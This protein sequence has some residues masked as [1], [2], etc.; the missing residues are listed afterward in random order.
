MFP[1][2]WIVI[3][4]LLLIILIIFIKMAIKIVQE[5]E[6]MV[7]ERFGKFREVLGPG[8]HVIVPI[9]D[10]ARNYQWEYMVSSP[11]GRLE[12]KTKKSDRVSTQN[13]VL[14]FAKQVVITRDNAQ[15]HLDALI[16]YKIFDPKQMIYST[17]N[18]PH[19]LAKLLQAQLRNVAANMDVDQVIEDTAAMNI[20]GGMMDSEAKRWGVTIDWVRCQKV[21]APS[22]LASY[23]AKKKNADLE[24]K[25][26]TI[27]AKAQKQ[28]RIIESEGIRDSQIRESEGAAQAMLQKARG[29]AQAIVNAGNAEARSIKEIGRVISQVAGEDPVRYFLSLKYLDALRRIVSTANTSVEYLPHQTALL[30]TITDLGL[31]TIFPPSTL[32]DPARLASLWNQP[33]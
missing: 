16:C 14:D 20:M 7:I 32:A 22:D 19:M 3:G 18:L 9:I 23:L 25:E 26:I 17:Q 27:K 11:L 21:E 5:K 12:K 6:N 15:L 30:Q 28:S 8:I 29:Q 10:R 33:H 13:E 2:W 24:N 1:W 31:N 4:V